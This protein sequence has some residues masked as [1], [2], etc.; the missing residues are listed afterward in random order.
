MG[1]AED[2]GR[3]RKGEELLRRRA[4]ALE[5]QRAKRRRA[6]LLLAVV[7]IA[8]VIAGVVIA[9]IAGDAGEPAPAATEASATGRAGES[10]VTGTTPATAPATDE[11]L[12]V[13]GLRGKAGWP[14]RGAAARSTRVPILMYHLVGDPKGEVAYPD[15]WV[16]PAD[17]KA[18][19]KALVDAGFTAVTMDEVWSAWHGDGALPRRPVVFSFDDG[20]ISQVM[21]AAPVLRDAGWPGVLNLTLNH[22]GNDGLPRWGVKRILRQGWELGSHTLDHPDMTTLGA[23]ELRRQL[24]ESRKQIEDEFGVRA[25]FFCYPAGRHDETVRKAVDAAGYVGATT[26]EPGL[27]ARGDDPFALPRV[28]VQATTSAAQLLELARG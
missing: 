10:V 18:Q 16:T 28:R 26:T 24:V 20:D 9:G 1:G 13:D 27:A 25:G 21:R 23:G 11:P 3:G 22:L 17:F 6:L 15:L 7:A 8:G 5:R 12:D 14:V 4:V 2:P 19:V